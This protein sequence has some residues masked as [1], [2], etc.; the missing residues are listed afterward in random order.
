MHLRN[1]RL[2][3]SL[4]AS[5]SSSR[6][7]RQMSSMPSSGAGLA[8]G[9]HGRHRARDPRGR[10]AADA[11]EADLRQAGQRR[12]HPRHVRPPH[13]AHRQTLAQIATAAGW[14]TLAPFIG[15][16]E[17]EASLANPDSLIDISELHFAYNDRP[18]LKG[19][20][21]QVPRGKLV[22]ILGASGSGKTTLLNLIGGQLKPQAG[23]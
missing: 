3:S 18:V 14:C 7:G 9:D 1:T 12:Q 23:E 15:G 22:A 13:P 10:A 6:I 21:L 11:F 8:A 20:S 5:A 16:R 17:S 19:I 2:S 4:T